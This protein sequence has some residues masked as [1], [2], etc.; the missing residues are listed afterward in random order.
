MDAIDA[1]NNWFIGLEYHDKNKPILLSVNIKEVPF[2]IH[3]HLSTRRLITALEPSNY[4]A[5]P[6]TSGPTKFPIS[7]LEDSVLN[8]T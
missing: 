8:R 7:P 6:D 1:I 4:M 3:S 5:L 2:F